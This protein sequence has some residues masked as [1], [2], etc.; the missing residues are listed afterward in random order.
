MR[1][2]LWRIFG[3]L[4]ALGLTLLAGR[5]AATEL[6]YQQA[7]YVDQWVDNLKVTRI[8]MPKRI[9]VEW[10]YTPMGGATPQFT[11][12]RTPISGG[13]SPL[14]VTLTDKFYEDTTFDFGVTYEYRVKVAYDHAPSMG[15]PPPPPGADPNEIYSQQFASGSSPWVVIRCTAAEV[16]TTDNQAA[17]SRY[18]LRYGN[19]TF[20]DFA[21]GNRTYR[22]G[23]FAGY[24]Q[25]PS[26][27]GRSYLKF[28]FTTPLPANE[29]LWAGSVSAYHTQSA[30]SG[31]LTV[32]AQEVSTT[33]TQAGLKWT[34]APSLLPGSPSAVTTV[35]WDSANPQP[36]WKNWHFGFEIAGYAEGGGT[37]GVGLASTSE[38]TN[39]W[40]Y[41]A[42]KEHSSTYRPRVVY[43]YGGPVFPMELLIEPGSIAVG[44]T[45]TG[46]V[47]L[48]DF[49]PAG[50][51]VVTLS[52][53]GDEVD[54]P[55]SVTIP[56]GQRAATFPIVGTDAGYPI[57]WAEASG[58]YSTAAMEVTG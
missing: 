24:A 54:I 36:A 48:N 50:G 1:K 51:V 30:A 47:R 11:F 20:L 31:T 14:A 4:T 42:K 55:V 46:T 49:A 56:A 52:T 58:L 41:F 28:P 3:L 43:A 7:V 33:W 44:N 15:L 2:F 8:T 21:F 10:E 53:W 13:G 22:G 19:P 12:Y 27:V 26:R 37:L 35:S 6:K 29:H 17:D 39:G 16:L 32:G 18:D 40:A 5:P 23:L 34:T 25:D 57:I 45:A 9:R 38:T